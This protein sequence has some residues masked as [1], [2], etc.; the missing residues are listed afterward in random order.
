M[1]ITF[2]D[3]DLA[4]EPAI[5]WEHLMR[6]M[7]SDVYQP[8]TDEETIAYLRWQHIRFRR[9]QQKRETNDETKNSLL[10]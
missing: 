3:H 6:K 5:T 2:T 10:R 8:L 7:H 4:T 9:Q 1:S